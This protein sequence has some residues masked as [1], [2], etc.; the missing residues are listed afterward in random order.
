[1]IEGYSTVK[2]TATKWGLNIRTVQIMCA[3]ERIPGAI[4]FGR[5]W[6]IPVEAEKP[7]DK[8]IVTGRYRDWRKKNTCN[9]EK[10]DI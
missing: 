2:E 3:D 9:D 7:I 1:M 5:N 10:S 6:A 4:K 8:R